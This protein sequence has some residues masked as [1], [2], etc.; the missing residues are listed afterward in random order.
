LSVPIIMAV[1][2][3]IVLAIEYFQPQP[4]KAIRM[5]KESL[6]RKE[7]FTV[8]QY[9][10]STIY[11]EKDKGKAIEIQGWQAERTNDQ[12]A[13]FRVDFTYT[14]ETG[15]HLARWGVDLEKKKVTPL[16]EMASDLSWH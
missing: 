4:V 1:I 10:Y 6:S 13:P 9:L 2:V 16:N 3:A 7:N 15:Q 14:D 8:Q 5:V 12:G 11:F